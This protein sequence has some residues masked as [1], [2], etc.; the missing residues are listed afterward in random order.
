MKKM[1]FQKKHE[2]SKNPEN[3]EN[4]EKSGKN[5]VG[6]LV[7]SPAEIP[8]TATVY[9]FF[10]KLLFQAVPLRCTHTTIHTLRW[11]ER[12]WFTCVLVAIMDGGEDGGWLCSSV[13]GDQASWAQ[14]N[15]V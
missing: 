6:W 9:C 7:F 4:L 5:L 1:E 3:H 8:S 11:I 12:T 2:K 10:R 14:L 15:Q 13:Q